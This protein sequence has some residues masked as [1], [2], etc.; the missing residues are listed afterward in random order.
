LAMQR[1]DLKPLAKLLRNPDFELGPIARLNLV[2]MIEGDKETSDFVLEAKINGYPN[3]NSTPSQKSEVNR[4]HFGIACFMAS[5]GGLE[6]G[7]LEGCIQAA[8][9]KFNISK[10]TAKRIW[11]ENKEFMEIWEANNIPFV[12]S[13]SEEPD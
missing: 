8:M 1:G 7:K 9:D 6:R 2:A 5:L 10:S 12:K 3:R 4:E 13:Q 11:S